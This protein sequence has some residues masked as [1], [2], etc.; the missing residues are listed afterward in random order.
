[1][2]RKLSFVTGSL[3][4]L[5][6]FSFALAQPLFS[7]LSGY[8]EFFVARQSE[9]LDLILLILILCLGLPSLLVFLE[10]AARAVGPRFY[11]CT[12]EGLVGLLTATIV[13]QLL[14]RIAV[15]GVAL[16]TTA[17][18]LAIICSLA[19]RR[20]EIVR[21]YLTFLSPVI[22]IFPGSFLLNP[23]ISRI[24]FPEQVEIRLNRIEATA[25]VVMV[26]LDELPLS[27]LMD[28][29]QQI[30]P[31]RFPNLAR[32]AEE[33][34]WFRNTTTVSDSTLLS[35]P[36]IV[37]GLSPQ[38]QEPRLPLLADY[39]DTLFTLL[40][41]SYRLEVLE[42]GT[43][44]SPNAT[45]EQ[46]GSQRLSSLLT[47][48]AIVYAHVL[49]PSD[50]T[51]AL[52][53]VDQSWNN[54][55]SIIPEPTEINE[56]SND[57][58]TLDDF[59]YD[60][61][62][63]AGRF[64]E[65]VDSIQ[66]YDRPTLYFLHTMLPHTPWQYL[67]SGRQ[68]SLI[69]ALTPGLTR[70]ES[71]YGMFAAWGDDESL[72][73]HAYRRHLLQTGFVDALVGNMIDK[74]KAIDLYDQSLIVI[75]ADHGA[76]FQ[77]NDFARRVSETNYP[78][79]MWIPLF[80]K[81]PYQDEGIVS[82]RNVETIDILPTIADAL[83]IA[84]PWETDGRSALDQSFPERPNKTI[85]AG[86]TQKFVVDPG[87]GSQDESLRRKLNLFGSGSWDS[88]F[89]ERAYAGLLGQN[90]DDIG[91]A[92][93]GIDVELEGEPFFENVSFDSP[94]LLTNIT[95]HISA[96]RNTYPSLHLAV[97]VNDR[98]QSV[99]Q[100]TP[101][102]DSLQDFSAL[103][104]ETAFQTGSN[105]VEVFFVVEVSGEPRLERLSQQT[106]IYYSL[107]SSTEETDETLISSDGRFVPIV[108]RDAFGY[109]H[110][111]H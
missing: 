47:D 65:F 95:G 49:F 108:P 37:S 106:R 11:Q 14:K 90:V 105:E 56:N 31:I 21:T 9:P 93:T 84:I 2:P 96:G 77:T 43:Q 12:H 83:E 5:V 52:P 48:L 80:L 1:M 107:I 6:L 55:G 69:P 40:G 110:P 102:F 30:D 88:L 24:V 104:P 64:Q 85:L 111:E 66:N 35:V 99:T 8:A 79:V 27:S 18:L 73:V 16:V 91:V 70:A 39:P 28:E 23:G 72:A 32:F 68:Y 46:T 98:V 10:G 26:V 86:R 57:F 74:L 62:R 3:H 41:G 54:F 19:Y 63:R 50:L 13:L 58:Q 38:L 61:D 67:P 100:I 25:P 60:S 87:S 82:D 89:A 71:G 51:S 4:I 17:V 20:I 22:L 76:S 81:T 15:P 45:V 44:L 53:A 78:V 59:L 101:Q 34:Y 94:F 29:Q 7:L 42:N 36:A 103:V 97:A 75:T 109:D 33:S 92:E